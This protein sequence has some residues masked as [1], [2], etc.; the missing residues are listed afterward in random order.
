MDWSESSAKQIWPTIEVRLL[1]WRHIK[2]GATNTTLFELFHL[3]ND[4]KNEGKFNL[5]TRISI[6][7]RTRTRSKLRFYCELNRMGVETTHFGRIKQVQSDYLIAT[8]M[9]SWTWSY[10]AI[11]SVWSRFFIPILLMVSLSGG[12]TLKNYGLKLLKGWVW[13]ERS[14]WRYF[15][16]RFLGL[17][18]H[19]PPHHSQ[20]LHLWLVHE[21]LLQ[22]KRHQLRQKTRLRPQVQ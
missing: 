17:P 15:F 20:H 2:T 5:C 10:W 8:S 22:T 11:T 19:F 1:L 3:K 21:L 12:P 6:R 18:F 9:T 14:W 7:K 13:L 4:N 16:D